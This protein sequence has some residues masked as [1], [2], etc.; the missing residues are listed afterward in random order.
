[1]DTLLDPVLEPLRYAFMQRGL[2]EAVLLGVSGGL[3]GTLLLL[4]RLALMGDALSH[5]LLPGMA[6]A[7]LLVG[8]SPLALFTG[9]LVAGL[10]ASVGSALVTRLTRLKEEMTFA[11]FF[12]VLYASGVAL[13]TAMGTQVNLVHFLFGSVLA[14]QA[15]DLWLAAG[16]STATVAVFL[17]LHR[18]LV[19][20]SFDGVFYRAIGGRGMGLHLGVLALVVVNLVAALQ[21]MGVVLALGLF[22]LPA[23]SAYLWTDRLGRLLGISVAASVFGAVGGLYLS[24]HAGIASGAAIVIVLGGWF[25]VSVLASP[26]YGMVVKLLRLFREGRGV[27]HTPD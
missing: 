6:L 3:L 24:F 15:G 11:A 17:V 10:F 23:A 22:I 20:E 7:W 14:V 19:L 26:R 12:I 1:M 8:P 27:L 4:R 16:T 2:L 25:V 18:C 5:S 13:I 9:A 21:A